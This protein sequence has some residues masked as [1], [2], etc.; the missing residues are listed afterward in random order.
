MLLIAAARILVLSAFLAPG[1]G[2]E[3]P[4]W[5]DTAP[6]DGAALARELGCAAC[7]SGVGSPELIRN[8]APALGPQAPPLPASFVFSYLED[9]QQRRRDIGASRMP[10]FGLDEGER[11]ALALLLGAPDGDAAV[12]E[13]RRRHPGVDAATGR[14][15]F[16]AL[17]CAG[18]H[19]G[20]TAATTGAAPDLSR[21]GARASSAWLGD[22][23]TAP[24]PIRGDGHPDLP[25]ARMPDFRLASDEVAAL[26]TYLQGLGRSF[27]EVEDDP[28]TNFETRRTERLL[29]DRL[30]CMGCHRIGGRGGEIGPS[31][32]GVSQRRTPS[33]VL[34]MILD[35]Q[36]ASPGSP[37]PHQP[38]QSREASRVARYLLALPEEGPGPVRVSLTDPDHPAWIRAT[39]ATDPGAALYARHCAA[40]HGSAGGGNGWNARN[41]PV[42]PTAHADA[43]LMRLR[44]DDT[45]YDAV[46][47]GAWVLDGSPRMPAFGDLLSPVEIRS[48]VSYVRSLC[49][50]AGPSWSGDGVPGRRGGR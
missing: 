30:A 19:A 5:P 22:Y 16:D 33:Y 26:A 3:G 46:F 49:D 8:R 34:E 27:A 23:L 41:L 18:C 10:D 15:V 13:A 31:L 29:E 12:S 11:L 17:G 24:T 44:A 7:H 42:P 38:L 43:S 32:D 28:L 47:A 21:E 45:L 39:A 37:M 14:R 6:P 50:C 2:R 20:V 1:A 40:C 9:P 4:A 36:R 48:L 35:P 25:G